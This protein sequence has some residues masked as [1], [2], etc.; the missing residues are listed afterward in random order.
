MTKAKPN[1]KYNLPDWI[2]DILA[3]KKTAWEFDEASQKIIIHGDLDISDRKLA[4]LPN[5]SN[6][7]VEGDFN[8]SHNQLTSLEHAPQTVGGSFN[9]HNNQLTS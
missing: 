1:Y 4:A 7:V 5:L 2:K 8:C 6:V 3:E 9:C